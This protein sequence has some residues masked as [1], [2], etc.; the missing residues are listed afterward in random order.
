MDLKPGEDGFWLISPLTKAT[1]K[2]EYVGVPAP[3]TPKDWEEPAKFLDAIKLQV[4]KDPDLVFTPVPKP[5]DL[6]NCFE[7]PTVNLYLELSVVIYFMGF[8][9]TNC[10]GP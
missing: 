1:P 10:P 8:H 2:K 7:T 3:Q 4:T 5:I 6:I 9:Q